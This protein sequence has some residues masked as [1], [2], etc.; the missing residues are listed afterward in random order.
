M[1]GYIPAAI[2]HAMSDEELHKLSLEKGRRGN[3]STNAKSAQR[4]IKRRKGE[5]GPL[6]QN[7]WFLSDDAYPNAAFVKR[8]K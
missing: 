5:I 8:F 4:E 6:I 2:I 7:R 1:I 3:A